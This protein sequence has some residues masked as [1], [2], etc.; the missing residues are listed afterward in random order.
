MSNGEIVDLTYGDPLVWQLLKDGVV[1][2]VSSV[3]RWILYLKS[4]KGNATIDSDAAEAAS[5][6]DKTLGDGKVQ[7]DLTKYTGSLALRA[8]T[9]TLVSFDPTN[10]TGVEWGSMPVTTKDIS[11]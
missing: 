4:G 2:D 6:F 5:V 9:A 1:A 7:I 10:P 8:W 3:T 11:T